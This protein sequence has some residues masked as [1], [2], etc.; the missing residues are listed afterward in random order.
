MSTPW[1]EVWVAPCWRHVLEAHGTL[2]KDMDDIAATED[3]ASCKWCGSNRRN[4]SCLWD[5]PESD[6]KPIRIWPPEGKK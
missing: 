6:R 5:I 4:G 1:P 2:E 3:G